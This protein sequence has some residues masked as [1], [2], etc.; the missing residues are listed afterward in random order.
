MKK[1]IERIIYFAPH[2][3]SYLDRGYILKFIKKKVQILIIQVL[4]HFR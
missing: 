4:L 3:Y 2:L 1:L